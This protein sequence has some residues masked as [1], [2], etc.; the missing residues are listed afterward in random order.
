MKIL[1]FDPTRD[2]HAL[3]EFAA[4]VWARPTSDAYWEWW[5]SCPA[6]DGVVAY[7]DDGR[8]LAVLFGIRRPYWL[9]ER[10]QDCL[11]PFDWFSRPDVVGST[12][13]VSLM[14]RFQ[15]RGCPIVVLGANPVA[16]QVMR[17]LGFQQVA[18]RRAYWLPFAS[19]ALRER[20]R[21]RVSAG[22]LGIAGR[23]FRTTWSRP[24]PAGAEL[25]LVNRTPDA[26]IFP[27][28]AD[29][30]APRPDPAL[31]GWWKNATPEVGLFVPFQIA[32][33]GI[34][35]IWALAR[36]AGP[37]GSRRSW[38]LEWF[39]QRRDPSVSDWACTAV[40]E[41]LTRL[42]SSSIHAMTTDASLHALLARRRFRVDGRPVALIWSPKG[43]PPITGEV[44]LM[45]SQADNG[46]LPLA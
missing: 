19:S 4:L 5:L 22:A 14:R 37:D 25:R 16:A 18:E 17:I 2:A 34:P 45:G 36:I 24:R 31:L 46:Y 27:R 43:S 32:I 21:S 8:L 40:L 30:V 23:V 41:T 7:D 42:G 38:L 1:D 12:V 28:S 20:G 39:D 6:L 3:R 26:E 29:T 11:E 44:H 9:G 35:A 15:K 10:I 33:N 13:G